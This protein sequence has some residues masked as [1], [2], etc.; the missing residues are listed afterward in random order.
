MMDQIFSIKSPQQFDYTLNF[1][2]DSVGIRMHFSSKESQMIFSRPFVHLTKESE[3]AKTDI[4]HIYVCHDA[5]GAK[6][7]KTWQEFERNSSEE[8]QRQLY[9]QKGQH[10]L[11]Q[12]DSKVLAGYDSRT[13]K[14]YYYIPALD[15]LPFY[16]KAAPMRMIFHHLAQSQGWSLVHSASIGLDNKGILLIGAGGSGKTTTALSAALAGFFYLG[17]DYVLLNPQDESNT[18]PLSKRQ[19]SLGLRANPQRDRKIG[20]QSPFGSKRVF[21]S[22]CGRGK[23]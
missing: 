12:H 13:K 15:M 22:G 11:Y 23:D 4:F 3:Q 10:L 19:V 7:L 20:R 5:P 17:D 2:I 1:A 9:S 14:A 18:Q 16:E 21:L 6:P 8:R